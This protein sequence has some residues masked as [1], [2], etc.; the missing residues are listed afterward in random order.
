MAKT[1]VFIVFIAIGVLEAIQGLRLLRGKGQG[2]VLLPERMLLSAF[3][4]NEPE[5]QMRILGRI[6]I[7]IGLFL[8]VVGIWAL[9]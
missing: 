5:K 1:Y 6:R 4:G 2:S 8:I 7:I 3:G 9:L